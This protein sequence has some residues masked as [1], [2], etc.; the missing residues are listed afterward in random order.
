MKNLLLLFLFLQGA[1]VSAQVAFKHQK[2]ALLNDVFYNTTKNNI[3]SYM[4]DKGFEKLGDEQVDDGEIKEIHTFNSKND[5]V[6]VY[7][8]KENKVFS[9]NCIYNGA[10]NNT[11]IEMELKD[12]GYSAKNVQQEI[13]GEKIEKNVWSKGGGKLKFITFSNAEEK[14]GAVSYGVY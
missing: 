12:K 14:M 1:T 9:V 3:A 2:L 7:Y 10:P 5:F 8:T 11:F 13:E 4:K 6:N